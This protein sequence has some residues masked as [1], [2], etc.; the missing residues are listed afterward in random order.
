M[1]EIKQEFLLELKICI[2]IMQT[3]SPTKV[4]VLAA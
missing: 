1:I 3:S 4:M 2:P